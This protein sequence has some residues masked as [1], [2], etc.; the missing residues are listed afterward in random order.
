MIKETI[1]RHSFFLPYS[2]LLLILVILTNLRM[3][4]QLRENTTTITSLNKRQ[5]NLQTSNCFLKMACIDFLSKTLRNNYL[6][7][8]E[9]PFSED[10]EHT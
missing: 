7:L 1:S 4:S 2:E 6:L 9:V 10:I 8:L 5:K 3:A